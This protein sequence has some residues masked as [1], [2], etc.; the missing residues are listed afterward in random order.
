MAARRRVILGFEQSINHRTPTIPST[1]IVHQ[2]M[3]LH[4][5]GTR[6]HTPDS[7]FAFNMCSLISVAEKRST[8]IHAGD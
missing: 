6:G 8:T 7:R 2:S 3:I 1:D 4:L 5:C